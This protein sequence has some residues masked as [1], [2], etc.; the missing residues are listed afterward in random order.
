L[1]RARR[2]FDQQI[3]DRGLDA[4]LDGPT[5]HLGVSLLRQMGDPMATA[6]LLER[7]LRKSLLETLPP[8]EALWAHWH[9]VDALS[10]SERHAEAVEAHRQMQIF[11]ASLGN[12]PLL[13]R[14][15]W[16]TPRATPVMTAEEV[17]LWVLMPMN[18]LSS[19]PESWTVQGVAGEWQT[20]AE[21][22]L[23]RVAATEASRGLRFE[24]RQTLCLLAMQTTPMEPAAGL[25]R[26]KVPLL[27]RFRR[28]AQA[29]G[30]GQSAARW[31]IDRE[32]VRL[33]EA[34][35]AQDAA[36]TRAIGEG[37]AALVADRSQ[38][39]WLRIIAGRALIYARLFDL[40]FPVMRPYVDNG[41]LD[42]MVKTEYAVCLWKVTGDV[43][44][45]AT[46]LQEAQADRRD[47]P[48]LPDVG[49]LPICKMHGVDTVP[50]LVAALK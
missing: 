16:F 47:R 24:V 29:E 22:T 20:W 45:A 41:W 50:A 26:K 33:S 27:E 9:L 4:L 43:A 28:E 6:A 1:E 19:V 3:E 11:F 31:E 49:M 10:E 40:A 13:C 44:A 35:L 7:Y 32:C 42:W 18:S 38:S 17:A 37:I 25:A 34:C 36:Q 39:D 8:D 15:P 5:V 30:D 23:A 2:K 46:L 14:Y 21:A 48:G 12:A